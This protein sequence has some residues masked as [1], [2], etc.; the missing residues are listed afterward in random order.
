MLTMNTF[1]GVVDHE[2]WGLSKT[3][4][5]SDLVLSCHVGV[6]CLFL[7]NIFIFHLNFNSW[8]GEKAHGY[9]L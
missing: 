6:V 2:L 1:D 9:N 3:S 7:V 5:L 4:I 8:K